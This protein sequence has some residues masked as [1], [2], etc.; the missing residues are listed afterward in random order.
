MKIGKKVSPDVR[1]A[2]VDMVD[3]AG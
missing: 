2:H 1:Q 3:V